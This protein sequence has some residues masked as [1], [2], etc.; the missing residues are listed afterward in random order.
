LEE[1]DSD[2]YLFSIN[3]LYSIFT[4]DFS[5]GILVS[6]LIIVVLFICSAM[7]SGSEIA[8]FSINPADLKQ[9]QS[10]ESKSNKI[11]LSLLEI[12]KRLLATILITN[13]FVNVA[14]VILST[15]VTANLFNFNTFPILGFLIEVI[16]ITTL[17]LLFGEIMPKIYANQ[18]PI[19]FA[20]IMAKPLN[21]LIKFFYPL[22][23]LLVRTTRIIDKKVA[24]RS[25]EISMSELSDA[26]DITADDEAP[27]EE[28][29]ILKGI[30][31]FTD[32]EVKEIMSPRMDVIAISSDTVFSDLIEIVTESGY[33]R[34]PVFEETFDNVKGILYVKDPDPSCK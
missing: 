7:I 8:F 11:I 5:I 30:V 6:L 33:S 9:L 23:S 3:L 25:P 12:P 14:I 21:F 15:Y 22:S 27:D 20:T 16:I 2:P 10:N 19:T 26:I 31:K 18:K 28:T 32:I 24:Q 4:G 17:I 29:K 13:N 1:A 34:I